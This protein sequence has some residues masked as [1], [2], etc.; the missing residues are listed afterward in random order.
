MTVQLEKPFNCL[1]NFIKRSLKK[2]M[3]HSRDRLRVSGDMIKKILAY[4]KSMRPIIDDLVKNSKSN[5]NVIFFTSEDEIDIYIK[6][7]RMEYKATK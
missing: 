1:K 5:L 6:E 3:T 2:K 4:R 7:I